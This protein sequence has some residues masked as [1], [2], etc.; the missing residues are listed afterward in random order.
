MGHGH[1]KVRERV[2]EKGIESMTGKSLGIG[3]LD[4][5]KILRWIMNIIN[6]QNRNWNELVTLKPVV[7]QPKPK[8]SKAKG[9]VKQKLKQKTKL[10]T[11]TKNPKK[12]HKN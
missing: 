9:L 12:E 4:W 1:K 7:A 3:L 6:C 8:Q 2:R 5:E 11:K 10:N